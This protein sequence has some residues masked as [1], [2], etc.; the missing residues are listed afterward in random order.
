MLKIIKQILANHKKLWKDSQ[1]LLRIVLHTAFLSVSIILT[2][3]AVTYTDGYSGLNIVPDILLDHIP[4]MDVGLI[5][6]QG[7]FIFILS[8]LGLAILMPEAIPFGLA[9][10][11]LFFLV[12]AGFM[13]M[14]HLSAPFIAHYSYINYDSLIPEV[15]FSM[16]SG[17][18]MFFSGHT[19]FPFM[20]A[21]MFWQHKYL[22]YYFLFCSV[23]AGAAVIVGHLHYSIDVFS[24][25][26]I[27][28]G[29][30][31]I[32]KSL[33]KKEYEFFENIPTT[34]ISVSLKVR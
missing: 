6:F 27:G 11:A 30:F 34:E 13:S 31:V 9:G 18:D 8:L 24:A 10:A 33:F 16:N 23:I 21:I 20:L 4:K 32:A 3:I 26:F 12:R 7:S 29:I 28:Y 1:F 19:G 22:K 2:Y 15:I 14:T 5:F 17:N 25:F